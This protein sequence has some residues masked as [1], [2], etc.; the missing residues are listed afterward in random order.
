MGSL[1]GQL[2][3][4]LRK[5]KGALKKWNRDN[6]NVL[7]NRIVECEDRIKMIDG[8]SDQRVL[9]EGEMEELKR[10][11]V[12]FWEAMKFKESL[13]RQK[14][15][16]MWLKEGDANTAFFHRAIK[17]KAKKKKT[18][19]RMKIG[20]SWCND[21]K[22][23][24]MK[25]YDFFKN[26]FRGSGRNWRMKME[27]DFKRLKESDAKKLEVPFSIEEIRDAIWS[28]EEIKAP[29]PNGFNMCFFRRCWNI[30]KEDVFRMMSDFHRIGKLEKSINC[31]FIVLIPKTDNPNKIADFRPICLVSSLYKIVAKV[32]SQRLRAIIGELVSETQCVFIRRRQIFY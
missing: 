10:L 23:L 15:R 18:I 9:N 1:N 24:K 12:E 2:T 30:V 31:S 16:M 26:H 6:H 19:Y 3:R 22:E 21:P 14:S 17:I 8:I 7:E 20:R 4:K 25:V 32:L 11:N 29:G 13:W 27:L 5:L 28:C